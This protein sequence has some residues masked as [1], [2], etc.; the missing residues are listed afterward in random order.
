MRH[1]TLR[2]RGA[3]SPRPAMRGRG[4][5]DRGLAPSDRLRLLAAAAVLMS[6]SG[7]SRNPPPEAASGAG[8]FTAPY[9]D[10]EVV[11]ALEGTHRVVLEATRGRRD[12]RTVEGELRLALF[13]E[14]GIDTP[15]WA[16][17]PDI[18][19]ALYGATD[20]A[21]GEVGGV[22]DGSTS[23]MDPQAAGVLVLQQRAP[24]GW[25]VTIRMGARSNR[26]DRPAIEGPYAALTVTEL[27]EDGVSGTWA[28]GRSTEEA[29]GTFSAE[30]VSGAVGSP[31]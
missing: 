29:G 5:R 13:P 30:R 18:R 15:A 1:P 19:I 27:C 9:G 3:P 31:E 12:G 22:A 8:C 7:C 20:L 17:D 21:L 10:V 2:L 11:R 28:S 23:S 25:S 16:D 26:F 6:I 4:P 14:E 24:A